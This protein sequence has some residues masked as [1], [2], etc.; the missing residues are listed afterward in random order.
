MLAHSNIQNTSF[1]FLF[2]RKTN[3]I[4]SPLYHSQ[5]CMECKGE[6]VCIFPGR[7]KAWYFD[8][9]LVK[10]SKKIEGWKMRYLSAGARLLLIKHVL[11]SL[12]M[13]LLSV[14]PVPKQIFGK[15]NR[16]FSTFFWGAS[17]G[18]PKRKWVCWDSVCRPVDEGGVGIRNIMDVYSSLQSKFAWKFLSEDT[19]WSRF[20]KAKYV[21]NQ[22]ISLV[23]SS[24]GSRFWKMLINSIPL[25]IDK[26][27]WRV[28]EGNL[29]F[30]R[31][32]WMESGPICQK[33]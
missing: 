24:K 30:W 14:L 29:S 4:A 31:D 2:F 21:K 17:E 23:D 12:P 13:H 18:R 15:I 10:I 26:S 27:F 1:Y 19:L 25:V 9:L 32:K 20:F 22:H 16:L 11:S 5:A 33:I 6:N 7:V 28:K 3:A 8:D